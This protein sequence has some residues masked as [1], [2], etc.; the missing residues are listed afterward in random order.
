[1]RAQKKVPKGHPN[2]APKSCSV[3]TDSQVTNRKHGKKEPQSFV[4]CGSFDHPNLHSFNDYKLLLYGL[5]AD[6]LGNWGFLIY[7]WKGL[8]NTCPTVYYMPPTF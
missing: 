8:E 4:Y 7:H 3:V 5:L 1:V 6:F 2:T